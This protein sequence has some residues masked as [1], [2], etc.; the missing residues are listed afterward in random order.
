MSAAA[1]D[2][3]GS[4]LVCRICGSPMADGDTFCEDCGEPVDR[5]CP[6]CGSGLDEL[7]A[8]ATCTADAPPE[9]R[10]EIHLHSWGAAVSDRGRVRAVNEDA[11]ALRVSAE[12]AALVAVICD[13]VSSSRDPH[14]A[15]AAA[16]SSMADHVTAHIDAGAPAIDAL[17]L[18]FAAAGAAV[19]ALG[20]LGEADPPSC[21]CVA[22]VMAGGRLTVGSIGDSRA[23]WVD[24]DA[25]SQLTADDSDAATGVDGGI[26]RWL[27]AD[28][29]DTEP[30]I[31]QRRVEGAGWLLLCTDGLWSEISDASVQALVVDAKGSAPLGIAR[32]LIAAANEAGARDNVSV[33]VV[34]SALQRDT[35]PVLLQ[36]GST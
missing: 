35:N 20:V 16:S 17:R 9:N 27:G 25:A 24:I 26:T 28:A 36:R 21:T 10:V 4:G 13:G 18:G 15:A 8:C 32:R 23:Y 2:L 7:G 29:E 22:A 6:T 31:A 19:A 1:H 33:V 30:A 11:V 14:L 34:P 3:E 5:R 12:H